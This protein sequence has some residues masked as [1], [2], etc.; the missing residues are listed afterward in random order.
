M[1]NIYPLRKRDMALEEEI[2]KKQ[3][4]NWEKMARG[5][6]WYKKEIWIGK[7]L[8]LG[9]VNVYIAKD[10]KK[11]QCMFFFIIIHFTLCEKSVSKKYVVTNL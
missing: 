5:S 9:Y 3:P 6:E 11:L 8:V 10:S 4:K 2:L 7:R 1:F